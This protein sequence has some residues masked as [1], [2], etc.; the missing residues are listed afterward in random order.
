MH[1]RSLC[2]TLS[3]AAGLGSCCTPGL[4]AS[5]ALERLVARGN[6]LASLGGPPGRPGPLAALTALTLLDAGANRLAAFPAPADLPL[7]LLQHLSLD[8][9]RCAPLGSLPGRRAACAAVRLHACCRAL[10]RGDG[11]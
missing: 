7:A 6:A 2:N 5:G 4:E 11:A 10:V 8:R 9:N 1:A 3:Q